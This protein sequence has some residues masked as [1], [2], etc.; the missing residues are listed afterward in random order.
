[1]SGYVSCVHAARCGRSSAKVDTP[2]SSSIAAR[3]GMTCMSTTASCRK[4]TLW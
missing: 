2:N 4:T 3:S 1:M